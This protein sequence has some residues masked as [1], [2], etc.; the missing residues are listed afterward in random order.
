MGNA[1]RRRPDQ[2][3]RVVPVVVRLT[4]SLACHTK[5][6]PSCC[7]KGRTRGVSRRAGPRLPGRSGP[8]A[9]A[10]AARTRP[11][12]ATDQ[13]RGAQPVEQ[14][15]PP[16]ERQGDEVD[17]DDGGDPG[18]RSM[19][20]VQRAVE[21]G[22]A[23]PDGQDLSCH[24]QPVPAAEV[25]A[26]ST[27]ARGR[28]WAADRDQ[29]SQESHDPKHAKEHGDRGRQEPVFTKT[30]T[31]PKAAP[32]KLP[33]FSCATGPVCTRAGR[34]AGRRR[35]TRRA[36]GCGIQRDVRCERRGVRGSPTSSRRW[37]SLTAMTS[38][39]THLGQV[40]TVVVPVTDQAAALE[41]LRRHPRNAEGQRR[42]VPDR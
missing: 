12:T 35:P 3:T 16:D 22:Q 21:Q 30:K 15:V 10:R 4:G 6:R 39:G 25:S 24:D 5:R 33:S 19:R 32:I 40:A 37:G 29:H 18:D 26:S 8:A 38:S 2:D 1:D 20:R 23:E 34:D 7:P 11:T 41:L 27:G 42:H 13:Q 28:A 17:A 14:W 9:V 31:R 36:A